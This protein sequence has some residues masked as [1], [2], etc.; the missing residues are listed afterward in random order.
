[1]AKPNEARTPQAQ[2]L[3]EKYILIELDKLIDKQIEEEEE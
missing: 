3:I 1:M 2:Y